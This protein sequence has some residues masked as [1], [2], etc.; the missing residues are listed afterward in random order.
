MRTN[1][2]AL[3]QSGTASNYLIR[4]RGGN[5]TCTAV[6]AFLYSST[7]SGSITM[8]TTGLTQGDGVIG[9]TSSSYL[10]WSAEL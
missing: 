9:Y 4:D 8:T 1:P 10:A 2:T 5:K 3:E 7:N 6:P